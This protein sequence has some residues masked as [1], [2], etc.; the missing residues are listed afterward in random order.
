GGK[1]PLGVPTVW[2]S[3]FQRCIRQV[4]D[5]IMEAKFYNHS[6]G[7]RSNRSTHHALSRMMFL[8]NRV[9]LYQCIDI[10]IKGFFDNVNH[11]K[12]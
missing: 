12:L 8:I 2:D 7:F 6:Y 4:L 9:G 3:V 1:R 10:D 5:P 11:G